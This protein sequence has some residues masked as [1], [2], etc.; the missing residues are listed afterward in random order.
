MIVSSI[1]MALSML[2][3]GFSVN[4]AMALIA[5]FLIGITNGTVSNLK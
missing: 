1:L 4:Y 5:R 2:M 3:F